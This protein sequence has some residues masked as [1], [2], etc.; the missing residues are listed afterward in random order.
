MLCR[1]CHIF[2]TLIIHLTI[3]TL[4]IK[5]LYTQGKY[6][7]FFHSSVTSVFKPMSLMYGFKINNQ[8]NKIIF[9]AVFPVNEL[10]HL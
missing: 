9:L 1:S 7:F 6:F 3:F 10:V 5:I 8:E 4:H 2:K